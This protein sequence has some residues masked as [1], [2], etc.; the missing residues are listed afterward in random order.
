MHESGQAELATRS[1]YGLAARSKGK[2]VCVVPLPAFSTIFRMWNFSCWLPPAE[3]FFGAS[4]G[5]CISG[6]SLCLDP[7][8]LL[9]SLCLDLSRSCR[10]FFLLIY[11]T[12]L[13]V[14]SHTAHLRILEQRKSLKKL[15]S[16]L[17]D[18]KVRTGQAEP[19]ES[20]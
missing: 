15:G 20:T 17:I 13:Y 3:R 19:S 8:R 14:R 18:E 4:I 11:R 2:A 7:L 6:Q 9:H 10:A 16:V 12:A 1:S 5:C